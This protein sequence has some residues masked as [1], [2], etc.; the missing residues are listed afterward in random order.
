[1]NP[2]PLS[3]R[4]VRIVP[5]NVASNLTFGTSLLRRQRFASRSRSSTASWTR[6]SS[7]TESRDSHRWAH[8]LLFRRPLFGSC[9][10]THERRRHVGPARTR[11]LF[12][13]V[14]GEAI[15]GHSLPAKPAEGLAGRD[16]HALH[17]LQNEWLSAARQ[18]RVDGV[19]S[20]LAPAAAAHGTR[21]RA[22]HTR[23]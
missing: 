2:N 22:G 15:G 11:M 12:G 10:F 23:H 13:D 14:G 20:W 8:R 7:S 1:M 21:A 16:V 17:F 18:A 4:N 6:E 3:T 19:P 9:A 5:V